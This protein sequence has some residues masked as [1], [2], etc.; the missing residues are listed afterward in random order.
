M[1]LS[2]FDACNYIKNDEDCRMAMMAAAEEDPGDGSLI[3]AVKIDIAK[4]RSRADFGREM[5]SEETSRT[6]A[7]TAKEGPSEKGDH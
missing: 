5:E 6:H 7:E 2:T 3:A 4:A 1:K